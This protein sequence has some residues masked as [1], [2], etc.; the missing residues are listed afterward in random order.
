M[1]PILNGVNLMAI[2]G[3]KLPA[4]YPIY[5]FVGKDGTNVHVDSGALRK[6]CLKTNREAVRTPVDRVLA[7]SFVK[8]NAISKDRL[9]ELWHRTDL[10]PVI[11][12]LDG[13]FTN[14]RPDGYLVDG[15]HRYA[16]FAIRRQPII[17]AWFIHVG[18][19]E[20]FKVINI[21]DLTEQ[22]LKD[23]PIQKRSY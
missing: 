13:N 16:L 12:C 18:E 1:I 15:H 19:W 9:L 5:T 2:D 7:K 21:K 14:G 10:D 22:E 23:M 3:S 20:Q 17:L 8:N 11:F 4:G 6:W